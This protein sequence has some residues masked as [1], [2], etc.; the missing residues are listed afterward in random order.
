MNRETQ[1]SFQSRTTGVQVAK[2]LSLNPIRKECSRLTCC[3]KA[4]AGAAWL[5]DETDN[6]AGSFEKR[7]P[8]TRGQAPTSW[9]RT[10]GTVMQR[11][12]HKSHLKEPAPGLWSR[13]SNSRLRLQDLQVFGSGSKR[14]WSMKTAKFYCLCTTRLLHK[15]RL[16]NP[17]FRLRLQSFWPQFRPNIWT[18][19]VPIIK[20]CLGSSSK[21]LLWLTEGHRQG[22]NE[23]AQM[24]ERRLTMG[25]P[26]CPNIVASTFFNAVH[27]L[28][29]ELRFEYGGAK[30]VYCPGRHLTSLRPWPQNLVDN[31][32]PR[33]NTQR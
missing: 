33:Q 21:A 1:Q 17:N 8:C 32:E 13:I 22:C 31:L 6:D 9:T 12:E 10:R 25:A 14:I 4:R 19:L 5:A 24:P 16:W 30:P 28:P 15:L 26:K 2:R 20:N 29:K 18:F 3:C 27:L 23:G 7:E 11:P